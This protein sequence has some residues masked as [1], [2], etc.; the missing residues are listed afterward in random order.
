MKD[1]LADDIEHF[2]KCKQAAWK[3]VD[4]GEITRMQDDAQKLA[5]ILYVNSKIS[6]ELNKRS[7]DENVKRVSRKK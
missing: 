6:E 2:E 5:T 4:R 1:Q 7:E 3:L